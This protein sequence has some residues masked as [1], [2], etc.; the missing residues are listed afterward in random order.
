MFSNSC[1]NRNCEECF[2]W[3]EYLENIN[4]TSKKSNWHTLNSTLPLLIEDL[5]PHNYKTDFFHNDYRQLEL[6]SKIYLNKVNQQ[7]DEARQYKQ[8][9][10][11]FYDKVYIRESV[12]NPLYDKITIDSLL[13]ILGKVEV[14]D[15]VF[16]NCK[17]CKSAK[18]FLIDYDYARITGTTNGKGMIQELGI[19]N[20]IFESK[21]FLANLQELMENC[22]YIFVSYI[23]EIVLQAK[24]I[25]TYEGYF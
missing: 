19:N 25:H 24:E 15:L 20:F 21:E 10:E 5:K 18:G 2:R 6:V 14:H 12:P 13:S 1:R 23:D 7:I 3:D 22:N 8:K 4:K 11:Q 9:R 17:G 16:R